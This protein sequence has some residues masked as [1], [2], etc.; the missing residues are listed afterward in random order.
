MLLFVEHMK[1]A[2]SLKRYCFLKKEAL[3]FWRRY[4]KCVDRG[5]ESASQAAISNSILRAAV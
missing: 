3:T 1:A 4:T 2:V 5:T